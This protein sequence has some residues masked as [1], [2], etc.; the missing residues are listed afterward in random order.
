MLLC[1]FAT[2][3][4]ILKYNKGQKKRAHFMWT[5]SNIYK[6]LQLL[7]QSTLLSKVKVCKPK[8][9]ICSIYASHCIQQR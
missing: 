2:C 1:H 7:N 8:T 9:V 4:F 3:E 6:L 5:L